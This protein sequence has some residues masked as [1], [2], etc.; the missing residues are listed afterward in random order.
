MLTI[1]DKEERGGLDP[2]IFADI[3][4][5]QPLM[6]QFYNTMLQTEHCIL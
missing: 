3:I 6:C 1:A 5:E 2:P 4:C